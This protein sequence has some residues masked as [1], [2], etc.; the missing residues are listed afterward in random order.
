MINQNL[1]V[2]QLKNSDGEYSGLYLT[3]RDDIENFQR[4]FDEAF[5]DRE[6][7]DIRQNADTWLSQHKNIHR[8]W[9]EEVTT[10]AI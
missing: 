2:L 7:E 1:K 9:A 8:I 4:D 10:D 5:S 6:Q 3:E